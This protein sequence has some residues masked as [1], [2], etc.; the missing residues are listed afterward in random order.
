MSTP[1]DGGTGRWHVTTAGTGVVVAG[2]VLLVL[3]AFVGRAD[4]ALLGALPLVAG[5]WDLLRRP[6][7]SLGLSLA[8]PEKGGGEG[9]LRSLLRIDS[10]PGTEAVAVGIYREG[11]PAADVL[12]AASDDGTSPGGP[13]RQVS[14]LV[15]TVRTGPQEVATV[16]AQGVGPGGASASES[17]GPA[18]R[19][20]LVLPNA[21]PLRDVPLPARLRGLT[22]THGS[23]RPGEGGDL[24]DVHPFRPGDRLR[25]ID[26]RVTAK[27]SPDLGELYVRGEHALAEA[28]VMLVVDS[29]DD[30]GPDPR[31]WAG[32]Q[33]VRPDD[34]T[35]LDVARRAAASVARAFLAG[36]DRVGLDDL[37]VLRRPLQ[38][39]GGR[40]QLDRITHALAL[41]KPEG[42]SRHRVRSPR[43][44]SGALVVV[45]STFLDDEPAQAAAAWRSIGHRV[46]AVDT[47]PPLRTAHL[48]GR[49]AA[50]AR[51]V[52]VSREDRLADLR[53]LDVEVVTWRDDPA[54][55]LAMLARRDH[56]R[57]GA[58]VPR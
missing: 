21:S 26:W 28:A 36:G 41:T 31:T 52:L 25:R 1:R 9:E 46:V 37:G 34:P 58:G 29:R 54:T 57:P 49:A 30:V 23:R 24:R 11:L 2:A 45:F 53:D 5:G 27:R 17:A 33:S 14:L 47:L 16:E 44:P 6:T 18:R 10:P 13:V 48:S 32:A 43:L 35:S 8:R 4:V 15:Q 51:L 3:G 20:T 12:L 39:G 56:R 50:A 38:P 22:G 42:T 40:G 19:D 55:V 7:G